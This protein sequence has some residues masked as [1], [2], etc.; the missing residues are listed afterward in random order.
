MKA[1]KG[2]NKDMTCRGFQFEEGKTYEEP[3]AKLCESGFHACEHPLNCFRYYQPSGS[4][5]HE[6]ELQDVSNERGDDTKVVGKKI[7]IGARLSIADL[8]KAAVDFTFSRAKWTKTNNASGGWGAAQASGYQG[9]AQASGDHGAAQAS[10]EQG[11]A[12]A[13]GRWGAAQASGDHGVA[14]ASGDQ[15]V[16][17]AIGIDAKAMGA[18]G[19]WIVC[20]EWRLIDG[21]WN[22]VDVQCRKVDG[23]TIKPDT[24]YTLKNGEFV[25]VPDDE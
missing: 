6:V 4:V 20:A 9:A 10:G 15:G 14:Q 22:R 2:F 8:V 24:W 12:Q 11:A 25:E 21:E 17:S 7:T 1:Y 3:E 18:I 5:F 16:A 23:E 13:S 19:C